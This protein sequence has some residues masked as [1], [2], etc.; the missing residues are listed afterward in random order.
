[1]VANDRFL[2][3]WTRPFHHWA[4]SPQSNRDQDGVIDHKKQVQS[5][6]IS[7]NIC[8]SNAPTREILQLNSAKFPGLP[9]ASLAAMEKY[10]LLIVQFPRDYQPKSAKK[11]H[12]VLLG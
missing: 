12:M 5:C 8:H 4:V 10:G 9:F 1:L 11:R 2:S 7:V 3:V 6:P